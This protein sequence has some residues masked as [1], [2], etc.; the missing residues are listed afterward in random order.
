MAPKGQRFES[1]NHSKSN[2]GIIVHEFKLQFVALLP[3]CDGTHQDF[4]GVVF[5]LDAR[6]SYVLT[7]KWLFFY[8]LAVNLTVKTDAM[9]GLS[10]SDTAGQF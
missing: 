1:A 9:G 3:F 10:L 5:L 7:S 2:R 6:I 8:L 4:S